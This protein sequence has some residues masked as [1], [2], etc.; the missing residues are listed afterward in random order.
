MGSVQKAYRST[1]ESVRLSLL[2]L[3]GKPNV[4]IGGPVSHYAGV[5]GNSQFCLCPKGASSYTSR[6]FEALY[7]GC[8]PVILSD[9]VRLPFAD[10][11]DWSEF[12]I[13]WPM[14]KADKSL[15][16]YL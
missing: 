12:S 5:M 10:L 9:D 11:V 2:A 6:V 14:A 3:A 1:N 8:V 15:Y 4:S 7:A 16:E 13:R